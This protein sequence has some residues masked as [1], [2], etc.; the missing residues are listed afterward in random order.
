[1]QPNT[2][3]SEPNGPVNGPRRRQ[4]GPNNIRQ[5][6]PQLS[7]LPP[8]PTLSPCGHFC[9][10]GACSVHRFRARIPLPVKSPLPKMLARLAAKRL[11]EIRH[12]FCQSPAQVRALISFL[13][14][15]IGLDCVVTWAFNCGFFLSD[16][17]GPLD[18]SPPLWTTWVT[19]SNI[20][21]ISLLNNCVEESIGW[22]DCA[23]PRYAR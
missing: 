4:N 10:R 14:S 19:P 2:I 16:L 17:S 18:P 21:L 23:A 3:H 8:S 20:T 6:P 1:M 9:Y 22:C 12:V 7:L 5:A 13:S 15:P 11:Q